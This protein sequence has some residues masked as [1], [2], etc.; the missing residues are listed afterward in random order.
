MAAGEVVRADGT[1]VSPDT[2]YLPQTRLYYWRQL[3]SEQRIP[4]EESVVFQDEWLVVADK[5]HFLPVTPKGRYLQETLLVRLKRKLGIDTLVPMHRIDRETA[6]LVAFTVQ[7]HTRHAYQSLL[8]DRLVEKRYEAIAPHRAD[9][10]LPLWRHS[11][12]QESHHFMAMEE[13]SGEPNAHTW[14]DRL[15]VR[16]RW[17]LY[18]LQPL[19]G[20]KHQLRVHLHALGLPIHGDRIYPELLPPEPPDAPLDFRNPLKLLARELKFTDPVTGQPRHF[21]SQRSLSWPDSV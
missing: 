6:G 21:V 20:Q 16:G 13:V 7:P 3:P 8:R 15:E 2:A 10:S 1:P 9:L 4:F 14:M 17:A 19:S 12:L 18:A 11:R 5:P